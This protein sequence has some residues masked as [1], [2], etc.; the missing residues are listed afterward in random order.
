MILDGISLIQTREMLCDESILATVSVYFKRRYEMMFSEMWNFKL[1]IERKADSKISEL[2]KTDYSYLPDLLEKYHGVRIKIDIIEEKE[3]LLAINDNIKEGYPLCTYILGSCMPWAEKH[4]E[5][6][7]F[8]FLIIGIDASNVYCIDIHYTKKMVSF[9]ISKFMEIYNRLITFSIIKNEEKTIIWKTIIKSNI[10]GLIQ[11]NSFEAF[12]KLS[13]M[14][15]EDFDINI[16]NKIEIKGEEPAFC[17]ILKELGRTRYLFSQTLGYFNNY[18]NAHIPTYVYENFC[19]L[20]SEWISVW[21][22]VVKAFICKEKDFPVEKISKKILHAANTEEE[23]YEQL[24]RFINDEDMSINKTVQDS[25]TSYKANMVFVNID[26]IFNNE[27]FSSKFSIDATADL[28][29]FGQYLLADRMKE[30]GIWENNGIKFFLKLPIDGVK[31]NISCQSQEIELPKGFYSSLIMIGCAEWGHQT[32]FMELIYDDCHVE[33]PLELSDLSYDEPVFNEIIVWEGKCAEIKDK[34]VIY[35]PWVPRA[36]IY[37]K[38]IKLDISRQI[39]R[40][41][42]PD[43]SNIH[44]FAITLN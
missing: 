33:V 10:N 13:K 2:V 8:P 43:C 15:L 25:S 16:E 11:N 21:G 32:D 39:I 5:V 1:N 44:I 36:H 41:K 23:V 30:D 18:H 24:I 9:P 27:G 7:Y 3:V 35:N 34:Q 40:L 12:R 22:I 14:V 29:G 6:I 19:N 26:N 38:N 4:E 42:M 37:A 28:T 31:D 17:R 20:S